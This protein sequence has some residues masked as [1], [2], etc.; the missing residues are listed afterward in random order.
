MAEILQQ[1]SQSEDPK[2]LRITVPHAGRITRVLFS[3]GR[4]IAAT[5]AASIFVYHPDTGRLLHTLNGHQSGS[6]VWALEYIHDTLVSGSTDKTIRVWDLHSGRCTHVFSG[7]RSTIRCLEIVKPSSNIYRDPDSQVERKEWW[8]SRPY[9]VSGS[10][11]S[12][13]RLWALPR[14]GDESMSYENT[15][16]TYAT[17]N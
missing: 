10:R 8:P 5:D 15:K 1:W 17:L 3:P 11:D 7:H 6:G 14:P 9:L 4:I 16:V 2:F 12:S 13:L